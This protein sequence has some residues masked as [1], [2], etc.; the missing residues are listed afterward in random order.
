MTTNTKFANR[1]LSNIQLDIGA[2]MVTKFT[3]LKIEKYN[4]LCDIHPELKNRFRI[5]LVK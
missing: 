3:V 1:L 2:N 5:K 4:K